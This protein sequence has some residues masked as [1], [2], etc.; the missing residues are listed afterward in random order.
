ML[1]REREVQLCKAGSCMRLNNQ[2]HQAHTGSMNSVEARRVMAVVDDTVDSLRY[3]AS[4]SVTI[5]VVLLMAS[6]QKVIVYRLLSYVTEEVLTGAEQLS[7]IVGQVRSCSRLHDAFQLATIA[8][9]MQRLTV[10]PI[11]GAGPVARHAAADAAHTACSW[12]LDSRRAQNIHNRVAART[13]SEQLQNCNLEMKPTH[14]H[15][16]Q[17]TSH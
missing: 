14:K 1:Q 4:R 17:L 7:G 8:L 16:D 2:R 11:C 5:S 12:G 6:P 9:L 15:A 13:E 3:G 10:S